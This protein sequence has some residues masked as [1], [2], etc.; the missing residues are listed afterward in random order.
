MLV[1]LLAAVL[2][3]GCVSNIGSTQGYTDD[4]ANALKARVPVSDSTL[5]VKCKEANC[6]CMVCKKGHS[7]FDFLGLTSFAGGS[8][9]FDSKCDPQ[10]F[11]SIAKGTYGTDLTVNYFRIGQGPSFA[12]FGDANSYCG[13]HLGMAVQ[14]LVGSPGSPYALPS[15]R[16]ALCMLDKG[17]IPVY[18]L[19]S[20]GKDI[21]LDQT[22]QIAQILATGGAS[23]TGGRLTGP[24]GPVV[25]TTEINYDASQAPQIKDQIR[26]IK[27]V[28]TNCLVAVA[29]KLGDKAALNAVMLDASGSPDPEMSKSVDLV[30]YGIDSDSMDL[31]GHCDDP[32]AAWQA[33]AA[34]SSYSLYTLGKPSIIPYVLFDAAGTDASGTCK[35]NEQRM[36]SNYQ[37]F[38]ATYAQTFPALGVMGVAP[39][40]YKSS[41]LAASNPLGCKSCGI[42]DNPQRLSSWY[43]G[44]QVYVMRQRKLTSGV[45]NYPSYGALIRF[46][47]QSSGSCQ[48]DS[49][50]I[51]SKFD[52]NY[53]NKD[54]LNPQQ[55][56]LQAPVTP[57]LF[58]CD[59][60]VSDKA[61]AA[62]FSFP[63]RTAS[64][65]LC[66][67]YPE[68]DFY[69]GQRS[70]D[71]MFV[72]AIVASEST[73]TQCAV[74]KVCA[75]NSGASGCFNPVSG[76][77]DTCYAEGY[78]SMSDPSSTCTFTSSTRTPPTW[79]WCGLGLMQVLEPPYAYWPAQY[80]ADGKD[81]PNVAVYNDAVSRG[82][83]TKLGLG[84]SS[85]GM[86]IAKA[87]DPTAFNPFNTEDAACVGTAVLA[88]KMR[89]AGALVAGYHNGPYNLLNW[90]PKADVDKDN[91]F[92]AYVTANLYVGTW[93]SAWVRDFWTSFTANS[94]YCEA[95][96]KDDRT[97][98]AGQGQPNH[99]YGYNGYTD[100]VS[101]VSNCESG[102]FDPGATTMGYYY[103]MRSACKSSSC[104]DW[105]A[106]Y[107]AD[108]DAAKKEN[109][110]PPPPLPPSGDALLN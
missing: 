87:C 12:D 13:D 62:P 2:M 107:N 65:T 110:P 48:D 29:P 96:Y 3:A 74:A 99:C 46:P 88:Q 76:K 28:C 97:A 92:I 75:A 27:S 22:G 35:W 18:I 55:P 41:S 7:F 108:K 73:S 4:Y 106:L 14:W 105:Q 37:A 20:N 98:C 102:A 11:Q 31:T 16:R 39:Y 38:F 32:S 100:F 24:V 85:D 84:S 8:C 47:D 57:T 68:L 101:F 83:G 86:A 109:K 80:R 44:C 19:Y 104:P 63:S 42:G 72:R 56:Q 5:A 93:D 79:R 60:C 43:A 10:K 26:K 15:P 9:Y 77:A 69:A 23:V 17:V 30:A 21:N 70:L 91:V 61:G 25:V 53:V 40:M 71:P 82:M 59:A 33:A 51:S 36:T 89:D 90:D 67:N 6:V 64:Q 95:H 45:D 34:F 66:T 49:N 54:F 1:F 50:D 58:R 78:N 94:T 81:G 52:I 103:S